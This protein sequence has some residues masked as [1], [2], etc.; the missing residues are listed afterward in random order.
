MSPAWDSM[1]RTAPAHP[2]GAVAQELATLY[3]QRTPGLPTVTLHLAGGPSLTGTI[4]A[5]DERRDA[6]VLLVQPVGS[7]PPQVAYLR[8]SALVALLIEEPLA[9]PPAV[10]LI[11]GQ[12]APPPLEPTSNLNFRRQQQAQAEQLSAKLGSELTF[13]TAPST[14]PGADDWALLAF[15]SAEVTAVLLGLSADPLGAK[16]LRENVRAV[17]LLPAARLSARLSPDGQLEVAVPTEAAPAA[18]DRAAL[19][20]ALEAAL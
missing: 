7:R 3:Q 11:G 8:L 17:V 4:V 18:F 20:T 16:A 10:R 15:Y 13:G 6:L 14:Y 2:A 12:A 5:A 9:S 19:R 1:L